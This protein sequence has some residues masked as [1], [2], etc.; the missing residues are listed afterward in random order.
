MKAILYSTKPFE[1][2]VFERANNGPGHEL[3]YVSAPL[4]A[5]VARLAQGEMAV[6]VSLNDRL[7]ASMV[8][9]LAGLGVRL[10]ALRSAGY[11]NLNLP[12]V[13]EL[14]LTA[15]YVPDYSPHAVAEHVFALALAIL[16]RIPRAHE[17]V[18]GTATSTSTG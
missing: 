13:R 3:T 12:A 4:D 16:R 5:T 15:V 6:S 2:A 18:S 17:R 8:E 14:G 7:D 10:I 9:V 1:K 11:N